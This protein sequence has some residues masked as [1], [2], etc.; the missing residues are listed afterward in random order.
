MTYNDK[1]YGVVVH[2]GPR[3]ASAST[4]KCWLMEE[5]LDI[6]AT[7]NIDDIKVTPMAILSLA[8]QW[9]LRRVMWKGS[10]YGEWAG[11][12][13]DRWLTTPRMVDNARL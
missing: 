7:I 2:N 11:E 3:G 5:R 13:S 4:I 1:A 9:W 8:K 10:L 12:R 6:L